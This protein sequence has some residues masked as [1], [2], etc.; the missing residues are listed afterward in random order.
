VFKPAF[1][2][3][4][5]EKYWLDTSSAVA[6]RDGKVVVYERNEAAEQ[7][8]LNLLRYLHPAMQESRKAQSF[9]LLATEALKGSWY[10]Q[11]MDKLKEHNV[12]VL[13][14]EHLKQMRINPNKPITNLNVKS[15]IDWFDVS[16]QI[17]FGE[18]EV[19]IAEVKKALN[20]KQSF[21]QLKD[22]SIGLFTDEWM[23]KYALMLKLG[24]EHLK[25]M[26]INPNKPI[27]NLNVKSGIDWFDV[28]VQI[29]F[30]EQEV[31]IAEVK[32][33]LNKKQSFVQLKDGSIGLFTDEWMDK[34]ALMLKL[35]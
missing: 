30:G 12:T 5:I 10:F 23:D 8:F 2:Y 17:S 3:H 11:F 26:R 29:S 16:V 28:S 4:G 31:S 20:K 32:K 1:S 7:T 14:Y 19:S 33:A 35:G 13:G 25:Q 34:Y 21:V 6:A 27:T 15:G 24:Y 9:L 22:G 18:Q